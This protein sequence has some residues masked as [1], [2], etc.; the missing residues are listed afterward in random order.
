MWG[1]QL[2]AASAQSR[3]GCDREAVAGHT[4]TPV[5]TYS[6]TLCAKQMKLQYSEPSAVATM[7]MP[8]TRE[9]PWR[10]RIMGSRNWRQADRRTG[11]QHHHKPL[12][13]SGISTL[14]NGC[15]DHRRDR[16]S[17]IVQ[18]PAA[19]LQHSTM[20]YDVYRQNIHVF[21]Y[22]CPPSK[23][24]FKSGTTI[25]ASPLSARSAASCLRQI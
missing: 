5:C 8:G 15:L 2:Y 12:Y 11:C 7:A 3:A 1:T 13:L 19:T 9:P 22:S 23:K 18:G 20:P 4:H 10:C 24:C 25:C 21:T 16:S 14:C 6:R 17:V